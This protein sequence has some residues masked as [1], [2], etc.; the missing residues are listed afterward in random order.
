MCFLFSPST[1]TFGVFPKFPL[2]VIFTFLGVHFESRLENLITTLNK[3]YKHT[4]I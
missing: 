4:N 2:V 3:G 1:F